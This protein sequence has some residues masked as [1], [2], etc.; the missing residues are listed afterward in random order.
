MSLASDFYDESDY[1]RNYED[2]IKLPESQYES[3][4]PELESN[5]P[6]T[7]AGVRCSLQTSHVW[8]VYSWARS[9]AFET[10]FAAYCKTSIVSELVTGWKLCI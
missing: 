2:F 3:T 5:L 9:E 8:L 1:Y 6:R 7:S 4:I 10:E